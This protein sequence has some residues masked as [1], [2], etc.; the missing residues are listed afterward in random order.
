M[1]S[2]ILVEYSHGGSIQ[3]PMAIDQPDQ[4]LAMIVLAGAIDPVLH[5]VRWYHQ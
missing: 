1:N 3:M 2:S 4:V 5:K